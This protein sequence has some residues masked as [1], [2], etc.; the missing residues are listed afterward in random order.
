[1]TGDDLA[2]E[3]GLDEAP[4]WLERVPPEVH[5]EIAALRERRR[6]E[7]RDAIDRAMDHVPRLLRGALKRV[8]F[9]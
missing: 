4:A 5:A 1:M 2:R 6:T 7:L 9:P 8:L 3:L